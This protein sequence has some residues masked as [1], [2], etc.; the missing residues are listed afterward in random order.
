MVLVE[1]LEMLEMGEQEELVQVE[2]EETHLMAE[3]L[4]LQVKGVD[5]GTHPMAEMLEMQAL[6]LG[7]VETHLA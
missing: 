6:D 2:L 3:R 1:M 7:Q 5:Q 4:E